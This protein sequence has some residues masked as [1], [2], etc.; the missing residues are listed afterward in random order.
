MGYSKAV[1]TVMNQRKERRL[2][3]ALWCFYHFK[4]AG[5]PPCS[6]AHWNKPR[7]ANR[8][9][10]EG[11]EEGVL[12]LSELWSLSTPR[13]TKGP[14]VR[15]NNLDFFWHLVKGAV[16]TFQWNPEKVN[17]WQQARIIEFFNWK[18]PWKISDLT[19]PLH[20]WSIWSSENHVCNLAIERT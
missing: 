2:L 1:L 11:E 17:S 8:Q 9:R 6:G 7:W 13:I 12:N 19:S 15:G 5:G 3:P 18:G 20:R 16:E 14:Q 10:R 4:G